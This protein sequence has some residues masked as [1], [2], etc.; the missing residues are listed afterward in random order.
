MALS[1]IGLERLNTATTKKIG[2]SKNL[3]INGA[4]Q[5]AQYGQSSS[6]NSGGFICDRFAVYPSNTDEAPTFEQA[7]VASGTTPYNLG[8]TKA[9]KVTNGNQTSGAGADDNIRILYKVESQDLRNSGWNYLSSSSNVTLSFY[10]KSSVAQNFNFALRTKDGPD[11]GYAFETGSLSADTWTKVTKT[12]P[13][14]STLQ[15]DNDNG[16]GLELNFWLF[17]GTNSTGTRTLNAWHTFDTT[18]VTPDQTST[19]YTT[20]DATFELTGV[21][22]EVGS[23]ATDFEHRSFAQELALCQRYAY[24][25]K[26]D[27]DDYTGFSAYSTSA[28]AAMIPVFFPVTM[29]AAPSFTFSGTARFQGASNDSANFTSGL[30]IINPNTNGTGAVIQLTG[31]SGMAAADRPGN[32]QFRADTSSLLFSAEL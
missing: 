3:L 16:S 18:T 17:L 25:V 15:F 29:R 13:G 14:D 5:V 20:N 7:D 22:L 10:V 6:S 31:S 32:L 11:R 1:Q 12:I 19:W 4:M 26:G 8:L 9:L 23:V 28:T 30:A 24:V 21:Q 27:S 2:T